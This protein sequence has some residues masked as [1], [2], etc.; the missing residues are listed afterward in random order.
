M[1]LIEVKIKNFR[2]YQSETSILLE[3]LTVIVGKNDAGKS[4]LL[5]AL[6]IFFNGTSI[7]KG[8]CN[9]KSGITDI[10]IACV[11]DSL[12]GTIIIDDQYKTTLVSEHLLRE[13]GKL[14]LVKVF[15]CAGQK[16]KTD[17]FL[18]AYHP[19]L[20]GLN[21]LHSLKIAELKS[22]TT[23]AGIDL[24]GVNQ[25]IKAELRKAIWGAAEPLNQ[26]EQLIALRQESGKDVLEQ[27]QNALPAY[28]LFKS[29]RASS[30]QDE[31]AQNPLKSAIKEAIKGHEAELNKMT[32]EIT[33]QLEVV[34]AR[35]VSKI[36]E[37]DPNLA[38]ELHPSVKNKNWDSLFSVSLTGEDTI[39][40]NKRGSGT[41]RLVL[42]NFFRAK[43]EE[44]GAIR[45][46]GVI[47]AIEEPETS[48]HPNH[49]LMLLEAFQ[50]LTSNSDCQVILT[51]H[52]PTLARRVP[53][54]CL[55][56]I[57]KESDVP[58][59]AIPN[60]GDTILRQITATLGVLP[61]HDVKVFL[62]VEGKH[63]INFLR[64][65]SSILSSSEP[66]IA[67]LTDEENGGRLVFVP[68]GGSNME[69]WVNRL[70]GL[71][72]P[73]FYITDRDLPPPGKPKYDRYMENWK[74]RGCI[75]WATT[76][77]ELENYIHISILKATYP[78]YAGTGADFDD[79]PLLVAE[80]VHNASESS[81]PWDQLDQVKRAK[82]ESAV[83]KQ[84]NDIV[85]RRMTPTLLTEVDTNG[86][87][88]NWLRTIS[89]ALRA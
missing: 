62:G 26:N 25:S 32:S 54:A 46:A 47:Y 56:L 10:E 64:H 35:T 59:V 69:L 19:S 73:E 9:V 4:T 40:I 80:A 61:D 31:E 30:D 85:I 50:E 72:R 28:A 20:P 51:T 68:L 66:D 49:Q 2:G 13:D 15:D 52:T 6:D 78:G 21:D 27:L 88:R 77:R 8:D 74:A 89:S 29:D 7:D 39:P 38:R 41:R 58:L 48:Q 63:D 37:M 36:A 86:D 57:D 14:E 16:A 60:N 22:R 11:F 12:P 83:K 45:D 81:D 42:L 33:R 5:D 44:S 1:R 79:V 67:N 17:T 65:I 70:N 76:K 84:L 3:N 75:A 18:R 55:R 34:T 82:K 43:A 53:V 23:R 71:N 87:I 24:S